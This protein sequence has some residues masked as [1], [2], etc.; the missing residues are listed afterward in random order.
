ME[1]TV[2]NASRD[3]EFSAVQD[4]GRCGMWSMLIIMLGFSFFSASMWA[5]G[6]I[7]SA[8]MLFVGRAVCAVGIHPDKAVLRCRRRLALG[9]VSGLDGV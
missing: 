3:Y 6:T 9:V 1:K 4:D 8:H 5:G 2:Q 7:G